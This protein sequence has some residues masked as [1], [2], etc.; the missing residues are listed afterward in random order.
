LKIITDIRTPFSTPEIIKISNDF[1]K[2]YLDYLN[3]RDELFAQSSL[4]NKIILKVIADFSTYHYQH[5]STY[6]G[7]DNQKQYELFEQEFLSEDDTYCKRVYSFSDFSSQRKKDF[8]TV[9]EFMKQYKNAPYKVTTLNKKTYTTSGGLILNYKVLDKEGKF[10]ILI[11]NYWLEKIVHVTSYNSF[12]YE[13]ITLLKGNKFSFAL[14]IESINPKGTTPHYTTMNTSLGLNYSSAKD[15]AK[16]FLKPMKAMMDELSLT[17]FNYSVKGDYIFFINYKTNYKGKLIKTN[18]AAVSVKNKLAY[19]KRRHS[20]DETQ[21]KSIKAIITPIKLPDNNLSYVNYDYFMECYQL[22]I[23][24][25]KTRSKKATDIQD[26]EFCEMM[27]EILK[28]NWQGNPTQH[29]VIKS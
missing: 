14:W 23:L 7:I 10:E 3:H 9:L 26:L 13:F 15:L 20:I 17:S 8:I 29:P 6:L 1:R 12:L 21:F 18:R 22:F 24:A 11:S 19:Y 27:N 16:E 4:F 5:G 2:E 28:E 25:A